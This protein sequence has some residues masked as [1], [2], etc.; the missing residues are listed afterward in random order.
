MGIENLFNE[1][2]GHQIYSFTMSLSRF[3]FI[4]RMITFHDST[5]CNNRWKKDKF[6]AFWGVQ[7]VQQAISTKLFTRWL[8]CHRW[9]VNDQR[10]AG[11]I[12]GQFPDLREYKKSLCLL[13]HSLLWETRSNYW[14]LYRRHFDYCEEH[15]QRIGAKQLSFE[16][17]QYFYGPI[18]YLNPFS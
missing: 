6:S 18:L 2:V 12:W 10:Q 9:N 17:F 8:S 1:K 4:K 15:C 13:H 11:Q 16:G 14:S 5:T 7:N 3:K